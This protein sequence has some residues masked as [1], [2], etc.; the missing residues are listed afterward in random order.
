MIFRGVILVGVA[1]LLLLLEEGEDE[2]FTAALA[3]LDS[4]F[5]GALSPIRGEL[6]VSAVLATL[7]HNVSLFSIKRCFRRAYTVS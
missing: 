2:G 6:E 3:S 4:A 1:L 5:W 7:N